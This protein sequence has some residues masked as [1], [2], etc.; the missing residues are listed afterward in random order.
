[1]GRLKNENMKFYSIPIIDLINMKQFYLSCLGV[2][3]IYFLKARTSLL[4]NAGLSAFI[5]V[6]IRLANFFF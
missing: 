1:M 2:E 5:I 4:K 6:L 3:E